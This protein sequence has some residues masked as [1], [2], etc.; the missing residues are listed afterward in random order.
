MKE[1]NVRERD[2]ATMGSLERETRKGI[3]EG[4]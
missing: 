3:E 4:T 1:G 2:R